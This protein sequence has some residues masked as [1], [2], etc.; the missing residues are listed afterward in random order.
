MEMTNDFELSRKIVEMIT[1][2]DILQKN[3]IRNVVEARMIYALLLRE[4][5]HSL[6]SIG[7]TLGKDHTTIIHYVKTLRSLL[8]IDKD[9]L[10]QFEQPI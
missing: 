3:R 6:S 4:I 9:L 7:S 1:G 5:G 2:V 8:D 10:T